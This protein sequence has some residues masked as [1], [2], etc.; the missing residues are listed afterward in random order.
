MKEM[1]GYR[2]L[3]HLLQNAGRAIPAVELS[4]LVEHTGARPQETA[5]VEQALEAGLSITPAGDAGPL[6]DD[7]ARRDYRQRVSTL[8]AQLEEAREFGD[9]ERAAQIEAEMEFI[10]NELEQATNRR[11]Q[12]VR[13]ASTRKHAQQS[14]SS[15]IHRAI[16]TLVKHCKEL[17][18]HLRRS[19]K[20]GHQPEYR[21]DPPI[22]WRY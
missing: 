20:T 16:D 22:R 5:L 14:V 13:A 2:Y 12:D 4:T 1:K 3:Q 8:Q 9:A 17:G 6:L 15:A 10:T 7:R 18:Y 19:I 21:P 11:G